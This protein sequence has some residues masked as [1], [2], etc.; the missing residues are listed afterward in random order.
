MRFRIHAAVITAG[1]VFE[2]NQRPAFQKYI[3][4]IF[5]EEYGGSRFLPNVGIYQP[6]YMATA[7]K[8][9]TCML[10]NLTMICTRAF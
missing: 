9:V 7:I 3:F 2:K 5:W 4:V 8:T 10:C 1:A 6:E